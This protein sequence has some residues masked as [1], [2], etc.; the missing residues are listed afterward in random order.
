[1]SVVA[2]KVF[3]SSDVFSVDMSIDYFTCFGLQVI[4]GISLDQLEQAYL[5]KQRQYHPDRYI[6]VSD[7]AKATSTLPFSSKIR[8]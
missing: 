7:K 6:E 8:Q 1:M 5:S 4:Y 2:E 3:M